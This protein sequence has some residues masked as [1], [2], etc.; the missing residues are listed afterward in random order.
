MH[1]SQCNGDSPISSLF[2]EEAGVR[3]DD[4]AYIRRRRENKRMEYA[5]HVPVCTADPKAEIV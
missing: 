5:R 1:F 4:S 3:N 2:Y